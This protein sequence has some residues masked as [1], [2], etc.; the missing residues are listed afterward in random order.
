[1]SAGVITALATGAVA[2]ITAVTAL[3][4]LFMHTT[5]PAHNLP[6]RKLPTTPPGK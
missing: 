2:V 5:G 3:V 1:M 4:R 6:T